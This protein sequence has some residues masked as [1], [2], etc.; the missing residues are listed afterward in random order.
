MR[1]FA[2]YLADHARSVAVTLLAAAAVADLMVWVYD[3]GAADQLRADLANIAGGK[4]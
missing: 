3:L 4:S 1:E 2:Q